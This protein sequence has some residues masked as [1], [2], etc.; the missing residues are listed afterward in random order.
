MLATLPTMQPTLPTSK[1]TPPQIQDAMQELNL[2]RSS[3]IEQK[4]AGDTA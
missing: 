1:G 3:L 2:L 4:E